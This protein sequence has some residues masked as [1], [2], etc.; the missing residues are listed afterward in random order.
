MVNY[1]RKTA[2][3]KYPQSKNL[4]VRTLCTL[5]LLRLSP[6]VYAE[7][8]EVEKSE[9]ALKFN[10]MQRAFLDLDVDYI[11]LNLLPL[12]G[13]HQNT[14]ENMPMV[15]LTYGFHFVA[16]AV[17][18]LLPLG[19]TVLAGIQFPKTAGA[20]AAFWSLNRVFY[21]LGYATG[22]PAKVHSIVR[23]HAAR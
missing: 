13:A 4:S 12:K 19:R 8:A 15:Y 11:K 2:G 14:L 3:I 16:V 20:L 6:P 5:Y 18:T 21:T 23:Y 7:K 1:H 17:L 22:D 10:C 9:A